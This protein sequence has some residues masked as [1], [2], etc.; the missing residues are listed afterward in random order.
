MQNP[1]YTRRLPCRL[2]YQV[3]FAPLCISYALDVGGLIHGVKE[4]FN[5]RH[6]S[7][8]A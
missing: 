1:L 6:H 3:T 2:W 8:S 5:L 7:S 4:A